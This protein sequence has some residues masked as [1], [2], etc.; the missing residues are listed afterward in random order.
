MAR[1]SRSGLG[2][3]LT[4]VTGGAACSLAPRY[5]YTPDELR[6]EV[7]RRGLP[8]SEVV[9]PYEIPEEQARL[10]RELVKDAKSDL[11]RVRI[12]AHAL[13]APGPFG[14][15]YGEGVTQDAAATLRT[16]EGNCLA[17]SSA[18]VGLARAVG[19]PARYMDA[20]TRVH[21]TRSAED[22]MTV[23]TGHVSAIVKAGD[24]LVGLDF[25]QLGR[26]RWY[27]VID[28][29]E[30]LANFYN[31]RG[32]ELLE[33]SPPG[34]DRWEEAARDFRR[35]VVVLPAF[36]RAWNNLG[37]AAAH[38]GRTAEAVAAYRRAI[39]ADPTIAAP[40]NNL[41][42]LRLQQGRP[43]DAVVSLRQAAR[44]EP[45]AAHVW[46]NLAQALLAIGDREGAGEALHRAIRLRGA[47]PE[48][49]GMLARLDR[50]LGA[51]DR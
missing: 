51:G 23:N 50:P 42:S 29:V 43:R 11:E 19:L 34:A 35:A 16:Q 38:G 24:Q 39:D 45:G 13:F 3:V 48:A 5:A 14:L 32:F 40:H 46:F 15:R 41:G 22:G 20:S 27:R 6:A 9:V 1:R 2:L 33:T 36:A 21:E 4:L 25:A 47:W 18:Y 44:L 17:L 37:I 49:E 28:D 7:E 10:A 31:N 12:L 30:A 8:A 26:I